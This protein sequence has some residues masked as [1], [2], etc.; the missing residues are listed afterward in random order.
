MQRAIPEKS[1]HRHQGH[2]F[3][4]KLP[5]NFRFVTLGKSFFSLTEYYFAVATRKDFNTNVSCL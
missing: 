5:G 4:T 2:T 3:L 1:K